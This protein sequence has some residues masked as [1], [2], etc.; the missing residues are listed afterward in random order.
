MIIADIILDNKKIRIIDTTEETSQKKWL[1]NLKERW[2]NRVTKVYFISC[3]E[4]WK[5]QATNNNKPTC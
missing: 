5:K 3:S 1:A 2:G 4:E